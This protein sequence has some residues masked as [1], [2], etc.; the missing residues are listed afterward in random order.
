MA[1][2][3]E[4]DE[5]GVLSLLE[6][7]G[8]HSMAVVSHDPASHQARAAAALKQADTVAE[9]HHHH[10]RHHHHHHNNNDN[11]DND[12][13]DNQRTQQGKAGERPLLAGP[14]LSPSSSSSS[15]SSSSAASR[16]K[17]GVG[18]LAVALTDANAIGERS[19]EPVKSD[20]G[21]TPTSPH[22]ICLCQAPARIPRPRNG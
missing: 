20:F 5:A 18:M 17:A 9:H 3:A 12:N 13:N 19:V 15:S 21:L 6:D 14:A 10:H 1:A 7:P 8:S 22:S 16:A 2:D 4:A 11:N